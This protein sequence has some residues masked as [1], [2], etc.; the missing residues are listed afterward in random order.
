MK[1]NEWCSRP[2]RDSGN[3]SERF[4]ATH[5]RETRSRIRL[6][7]LQVINPLSEGDK[8]LSTDIKPLF[9]ARIQAGEFDN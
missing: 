3:R 9:T 5:E 1:K 2:E 4:A 7:R 8:S 6:E